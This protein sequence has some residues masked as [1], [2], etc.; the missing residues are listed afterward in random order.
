MDWEIPL[1]Y[2]HV[3]HKYLL[4]E[5]SGQEN[6]CLLGLPGKL[7]PS[8]LVTLDPFRRESKISDPPGIHHM[9][10]PQSLTR[11]SAVLRPILTANECATNT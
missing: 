2:V 4:S 5:L 6:S 11:D 9:S 1:S 10:L 8:E 7:C 3:S